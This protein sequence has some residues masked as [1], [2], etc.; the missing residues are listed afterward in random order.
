VVSGV[1]TIMK[2]NSPSVY[3]LITPIGKNT[4]IFQKVL[5]HTSN[6]AVSQAKRLESSATPLWET[7]ISQNDLHLH[8]LPNK[9]NNHQTTP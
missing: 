2:G 9:L 1:I 8:N 6:N 7:Q 5:N 4:T 3:G